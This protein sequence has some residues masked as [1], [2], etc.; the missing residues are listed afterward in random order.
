VR[1]TEMGREVDLVYTGSH[2]LRSRPPSRRACRPRPPPAM[3]RT[4][5]YKASLSRMNAI[6]ATRQLG[7]CCELYNAALQERRDAYRLAGISITQA[8]QSRQLP[9][10]KKLRPDLGEVGSQVLQDVLQRLDRAYQAFFR[11][12][13]AGQTPG[14][15]RFRSARRYD[16]LTFKQAGWSLGPVSTSGKKRTLTLHGIGKMRVFWSRALEGL[17]KTV[18]LKR[19][20]CGDWFVLFSCDDVPERLLPS[21]GSTIGIDLGL[22]SFLTT[23]DGEHVANPRPLRAATAGMRKAQRVVSKRARGGARRSKAVRCLA[24]RHRAVERVRR[25]FHHKTAL[26]L[27]QRHDVIAV[28]DLNIVGLQRG[29]LAKSVS[30]AGWGQ[31]LTILFDKAA[32][33]GR[34]MIAVNPR[35]TSQTCSACQHLPITRK[36]LSQRR[37]Q[38]TACGYET[39]RD[40]NAARNIL[41]LG[42]TITGR[43]GP[44]ASSPAFKAAA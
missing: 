2:D 6:A 15:P 16:S 27:V 1:H 20:A 29:M 44:S 12:V 40:V 14:F 5:K 19:D 18:T 10:I 13:K 22:E 3:R 11:R 26:R 25:D 42:E 34:T 32:S 43:A 37:H 31:F 7:L 30:D 36:S 23:S 9:E 35:G 28:E 41:H 33:A 4:F 17:V 24:K 38:C 8:A 39:H 21:T